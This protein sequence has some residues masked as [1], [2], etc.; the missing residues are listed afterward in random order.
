M[1][2][3]FFNNYGIVFVL[4]NLYLF[5]KVAFISL[6]KLFDID[7]I[8]WMVSIAVPGGIIGLMSVNQGNNYL[9]SSIDKNPNLRTRTYIL[10]EDGDAFCHTVEN[11][12]PTLST[13]GLKWK[14]VSS[15]CSPTNEYPYILKAEVPVLFFV[16]DLEIRMHTSNDKTKVYVDVYSSSRLGKNDFGENKRHIINLFNALDEH[17][18]KKDIIYKNN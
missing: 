6:K 15:N 13:Y 9:T 4:W 18:D 12:I 7:L 14:L 11:L 8:Y 1:K 16:D 10:N 3:N 5:L 17:F 2:N